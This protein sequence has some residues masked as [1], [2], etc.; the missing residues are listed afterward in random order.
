MPDVNLEPRD[1]FISEKIE[2]E[3]KEGDTLKTARIK[4]L[5]TTEK[6][7][8]D[9]TIGSL[10]NLI[11]EALERRQFHE[12]QVAFQQEEIDRLQAQIDKFTPEVEAKLAK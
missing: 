8:F 11:K 3:I 5:V 4:N 12:S 1:T 7:Q 2:V 9:G 10:E 6:P